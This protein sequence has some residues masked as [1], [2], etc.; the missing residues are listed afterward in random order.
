M[1]MPRFVRAALSGEALQVYGDG[2]QTRCFCHVKDTVRAVIGLSQET[3]A[4]GRV[5]NVGSSQETSILALAARV[6][7]LLKSS[8]QIVFVPYEQIYGSGFEDTQRRVPD[9]QRIRH[10]L[11]WETKYT[12]DDIILDIADS[13]EA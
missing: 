11:G 12:L 8:S 13:I 3:Q 9:I 7:A 10:L 1:V 2:S 6:I 5:F 4:V